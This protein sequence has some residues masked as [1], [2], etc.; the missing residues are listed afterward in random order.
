MV[1]PVICRGPGAGM[2]ATVAGMKPINTVNAE[3]YTWGGRCDGW[4]LARSAAL[5]VIEERMPPGATEVEH[6]HTRARQFFYVI[7]GRLSLTVERD[8]VH[9]GPRQG[10]EITPGVR[11]RA[12]NGGE[13]PV[14]FVLASA[15]PAQGDR[16]NTA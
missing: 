12:F 1:G 2:P 4:H 13:E 5:S 10:L 8:T 11:H 14:E 15:P 6:Y 7:H 3:H 9:L 16:I